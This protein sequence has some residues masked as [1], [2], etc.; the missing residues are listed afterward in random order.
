M[1]LEIL[2]FYLGEKFIQLI[3]ITQ[4][5]KLNFKNQYQKKMTKWMMNEVHRVMN[6]KYSTVDILRL[7]S[8]NQYNKSWVA[9]ALFYDSE[10]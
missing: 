5:L 1:L 8:D 4:K 9:W 3:N 10:K 6:F 2:Q 7:E